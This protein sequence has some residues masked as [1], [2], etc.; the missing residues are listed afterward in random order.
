M[1]NFSNPVIFFQ[2][3]GTFK[4]CSVFLCLI[5]L[6]LKQT[7]SGE[8][9]A[10]WLLL[11]VARISCR[12]QPYSMGLVRER[13][14]APRNH[15]MLSLCPLLQDLFLPLIAHSP[16]FLKGLSHTFILWFSSQTANIT[17][18]LFCLHIWVL[19]VYIFYNYQ[20]QV[21]AEQHSS[22]WA[23]ILPFIQ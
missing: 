3:E 22:C 19:S 6:I 10:G 16:C 20:H 7:S 4:S 12:L 8:M 1:S 9:Q 17:L 13:R 18:T 5:L 11:W 14:T 21:S 23:E 15:V 2:S